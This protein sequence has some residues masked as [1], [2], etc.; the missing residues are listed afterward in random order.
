MRRMWEN[1]QLERGAIGRR[2]F[3]WRPEWN[4]MDV[5]SWFR[6]TG[7]VEAPSAHRQLQQLG[8]EPP[9]RPE[10]GD[11][12]KVPPVPEVDAVEVWNDAFPVEPDPLDNPD[13][14]PRGPPLS[15][16]LGRTARDIAWSFHCVGEALVN[17][18]NRLG[19]I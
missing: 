6:Q 4:E 16:R 15:E 14:V 10:V 8:L 5:R 17:I 12:V 13:Y 7:K 2:V 19:K 11:P 9:P 1:K 18:L 3:W